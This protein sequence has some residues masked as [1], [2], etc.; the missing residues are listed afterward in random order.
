MLMWKLESHQNP[1]R[2]GSSSYKTH[3]HDACEAEIK[4]AFFPLKEGALAWKLAWL[5]QDT[6]IRSFETKVEMTKGQEVTYVIRSTWD[7]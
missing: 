6:A 1:S 5:L 7:N 2:E 4:R 3:N